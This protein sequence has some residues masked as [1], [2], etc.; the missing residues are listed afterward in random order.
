MIGASRENL[1][2]ALAK[3]VA[4]GHVRLEGR[5]IMI[6]DPNHLSRLAGAKE[7]KLRRRNL[8]GC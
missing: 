3:L 1:N 2:R 7:P 8:P 6:T 5:S 4:D